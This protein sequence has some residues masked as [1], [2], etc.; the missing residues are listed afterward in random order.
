MCTFSADQE[1]RSE[2]SDHAPSG[3][4]S[5]SSSTEELMKINEG[6]CDSTEGTDGATPTHQIVKPE[7]T[8]STKLHP[9]HQQDHTHNYPPMTGLGN[10]ATSQQPLHM[11]PPTGYASMPEQPPAYA[12]PSSSS[13]SS[14]TTSTHQHPI[15]LSQPTPSQMMPSQPPPPAAQGSHSQSHTYYPTHQ[16][17]IGAVRD[18]GGGGGGT[19][20]QYPAYPRSKMAYENVP[21]VYDSVQSSSRHPHI[22]HPHPPQ[23]NKYGGVATQGG[24]APPG[25]TSGYQQGGGSGD[26]RD[27]SHDMRDRSHDAHH[28]GGGGGP[29]EYPPMVRPPPYSMGAGPRRKAISPGSLSVAHDAA[30]SGDIATLV[31]K[32]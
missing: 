23:H 18:G 2:G 8:K 15:S 6:S 16:N 17:V 29:M 30:A 24:V 3:G 19:G 13:S 10:Y 21:M 32:M 26:P 5:P 31:R 12:P 25:Q 22:A 20:G 7:P 4:D 11:A 1:Q 9:S 27:R 14:S 28:H